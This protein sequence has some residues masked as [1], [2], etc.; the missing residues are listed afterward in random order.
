MPSFFCTHKWS[1][2]ESTTSSPQFMGLP[3]KN[4]VLHGSSSH[5][6]EVWTGAMKQLLDKY[7][8][9]TIIWTMAAQAAK[10]TW[11]GAHPLASWHTWQRRS[12]LYVTA[13]GKHEL[14]A[15]SHHR[16]WNK[17]SHSFPGLRGQRKCLIQAGFQGI[18]L[19][20]NTLEKMSPLYKERDFEEFALTKLSS[21]KAFLLTSPLLYMNTGPGI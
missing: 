11:A 2:L 3:G 7:C 21:A 16:N 15:V 5:N 1:Q 19:H 14:V 12:K 17:F 10:P 20:I 4:T 13:Q 18:E 6:P 8:R 9:A